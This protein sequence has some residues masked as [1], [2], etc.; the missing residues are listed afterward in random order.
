MKAYII[1]IPRVIEPIT[2]KFGMGFLYVES[3][4]SEQIRLT[5]SEA[6]ALLFKS[7]K[8]ATYWAHQLADPYYELAMVV[9]ANDVGTRN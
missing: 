4:G 9:R 3:V 2:G 5:N 6:H 8:R 1:Q 7:K